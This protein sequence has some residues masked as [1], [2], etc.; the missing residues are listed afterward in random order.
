[1]VIRCCTHEVVEELDIGSALINADLSINKMQKKWLSEGSEKLLQDH[2]AWMNDRHSRRRMRHHV[3][4]VLSSS[5]V[6]LSGLT[7]L[8]Y[9]KDSF[10]ITWVRHL[11][12]NFSWRDRQKQVDLKRAR[13]GLSSSL[14][15]MGFV[16]RGVTR[17]DR[18]WFHDTIVYYLRPN[19]YGHPYSPNAGHNTYPSEYVPWAAVR[20]H[21]QQ[22]VHDGKWFPDRLRRNYGAPFTRRPDSL[23]QLVY[24]LYENDGKI[25]IDEIPEDSSEDLKTLEEK[26]ILK[27]TKGNAVI[28]NNWLESLT[29]SVSFSTEE[30]VGP[31]PIRATRKRRGTETLDEQLSHIR[32]TPASRKRIYKTHIELAR[33]FKAWLE[34]KGAE[35]ILYEQD[36]ADIRFTAN[37]LDTIAELKPVGKNSTIRV[38]REAIGQLLQYNF[39][40]DAEAADRWLIVLDSEPQVEDIEFVKTLRAEMDIP[41]YIFSLEEDNSFRIYRDK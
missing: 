14:R 2:E 10:P 12:K 17:K 41:L 7:D 39:Y 24:T 34:E 13:R 11:E 8:S 29:K 19:D 5:Y 38:I 3:A 1:M 35:D 20:H 28:V 23:D 25:S 26:G 36:Y 22:A 21:I 37:G 18:S 4:T 33:K 9:R 16:V 40:C 31:E 30:E 27:V 32:T 6:G 15:I